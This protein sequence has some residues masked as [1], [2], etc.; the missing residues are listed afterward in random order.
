MVIKMFFT[1]K[2]YD[3]DELCKNNVHTHST[4]SLCSKPEMTIEN[5][6]RAANEYELEILAITDHSDLG[7]GID[8]VKNCITTKEIINQIEP[9]LKVL[10]GCELSA[11]GINKYAESLERDMALE[12]RSYSHVHYHLDY[13]EHPEERT[14]RGYALHMLAVLNSLLR[15]GRAD[16]IA[17][18]FSPIKMNFFNDNQK[19]EML[20][21][22]TDNELG[23]ILMLGEQNLCSWEIHKSTFLNYREFSKRFF[24]I[25]KEVGVHFTVG[26][27]AHRL[28]DISTEGLADEFRK[29][30]E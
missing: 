17:H 9:H 10:A 16:N 15:S 4:F 25:G 26:T 8:V 18:P 2:T 5:M 7:S 22:I 14:P 21:S 23:D 11:Y 29:V 20:A 19:R 30:I 12:F 13:W 24:N 6:V 1:D 28:I 27:D 3:L